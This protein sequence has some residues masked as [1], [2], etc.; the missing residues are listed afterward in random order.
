MRAMGA[1][2]PILYKEHAL[3][4][5]EICPAYNYRDSSLIYVNCSRPTCSSSTV[6]L[7][8]A[9]TLI[10]DRAVMQDGMHENLSKLCADQVLCRDTVCLVLQLS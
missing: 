3:F 4:P 5:A 9:T 1:V 10:I 2:V 7:N 8:F 6:T